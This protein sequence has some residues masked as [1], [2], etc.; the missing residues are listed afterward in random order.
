MFSGSVFLSRQKLDMLRIKAS[1]ETREPH[2]T[3][4][5]RTFDLAPM[6]LRPSA[7]PTAKGVCPLTRPIARRRKVTRLRYIVGLHILKLAPIGSNPSFRGPNKKE[8]D[9]NTRPPVWRVYFGRSYCAAPCTGMS[10]LSP[11]GCAKNVVKP[12][13]LRSTKK[14]PFDGRQKATSDLPSLS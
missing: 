10:P 7:P 1:H 14:F 13:L 5:K 11:N 2:E 9:L 4:L 12:V 3:P 6:G 8:G